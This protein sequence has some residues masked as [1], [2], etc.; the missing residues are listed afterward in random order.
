MKTI[1]VLSHA[2]T[3]QS[4]RLKAAIDLTRGVSGHLTCLDIAI[5]PETVN[6]YLSFGGDA[7]LIEDEQRSEITNRIA[8]QARLEQENIS[9]EIVEATGDVADCLS[10]TARFNDL[11]VVNRALDAHYPDMIGLVGRLVAKHKLPVVAVPETATGFPVEGHAMVGWDGSP[12]AEAALR[13][14]VSLLR[15]AASVTLFYVDDGSLRGSIEQAVWY[16]ARHEIQAHVHRETGLMDR[17]GYV[18]LDSVTNGAADYV[19]MGGFGH[20]RALE[21]VLGGATRTMLA[22]SPVPLFLAHRA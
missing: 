7:L 12:S 5:V 13:A 17:A 22:K 15:H 20:A 19:V 18:L 2:D 16:L 21:A 14:A 3:G 11:L 4:A 6:D 10:Q 8:L 9:F 1:L